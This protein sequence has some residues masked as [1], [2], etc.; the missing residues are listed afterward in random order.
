MAMIYGVPK[1]QLSL[2]TNFLFDLAAEEDFARD[3]LEAF[4]AKGMHWFCRHGCHEL[5]LIFTSGESDAE[6]NWR[7]RR[8]PF[9]AM[10]CSALDLD[11]AAEAVC[12]QFVRGLLHQ[13]LIPEDEFNDGLILP[14]L[15][16]SKSRCCDFRQAPAGHR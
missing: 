6:R 15:R 14:K 9:E 8:L 2:D 1:R 11:S 4:R 7:G 3:L 12:E 5:H 10:G 16:W 13:R